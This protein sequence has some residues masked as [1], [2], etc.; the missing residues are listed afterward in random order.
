MPHEVESTCPEC[1]GLTTVSADDPPEL[2]KYMLCERCTDVK[3]A[4]DPYDDEPL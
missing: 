2:T 3:L 1:G 4:S